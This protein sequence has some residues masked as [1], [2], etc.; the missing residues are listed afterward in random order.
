MKARSGKTEVS[1]PRQVNPEAAGAPPPRSRPASWLLQRKYRELIRTHL[2]QILDRLFSEFTGLH[3]H[4]AW[5]T[6]CPNGWRTQLPTGCSVCCKLS[7]SALRPRCQTCGPRHLVNTLK[8]KEGHRF[9][10]RLGVR[11]YW[12]PI[13]V[14]REILGIAYLQAL[15][16]TTRRRAAAKVFT[17]RRS[18]GLHRNGAIVMSRVRFARASRFLR[19]IVEHVQ[20]ATLSDLRKADLSSAGRA[21]VALEREQARLHVTLERHLPA[22]R[23]TPRKSGPESRTEQVVKGLLDQ[24]ELDYG[25]PITLQKLARDLGMNAAYLSDV[26]SSEVGI[27]FKTYL[28]ELRL[29][30]AKELLGNSAKT[31]SE[32]AFGVGYSSEDRFRSAFR[33]AT[34]LSPKAWRETMQLNPSKGW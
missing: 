14:R 31:T 20:T 30:K 13:R 18:G 34:G 33:K 22:T 8:S 10:C 2:G 5:T 26:F 21:V 4:I 6:D 25:K 15:K 7:G 12:V 29:Q 24:I 17:P 28:T 11:N 32:V 1:A 19:L 3:F 16:H 27:P 23:Q 9:T